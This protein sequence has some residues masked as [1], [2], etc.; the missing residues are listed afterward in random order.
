M[1][2]QRHSQPTWRTSLT[3][4]TSPWQRATRTPRVRPAPP[5]RQTARHPR[6]TGIRRSRCPGNGVASW[7]RAHPTCPTR[8]N[9]PSMP[10]GS[11]SPVAARPAE[12]AGD[13]RSRGQVQTP[14]VD[15]D[16]EGCEHPSSPGYSM[17]RSPARP[18]DT[19]GA[20][21]R[22]G[23]DTAALPR[24]GTPRAKIQNLALCPRRRPG[25]KANAPPALPIPVRPPCLTFLT[26]LI[27]LT[28]RRRVGGPSAPRRRLRRR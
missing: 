11:D 13:F 4:R 7:R 26:C 20:A 14:D 28:C 9:C 3:A 12:T 24:D 23:G 10:S 16:V 27:R 15:V 6:P 22:F 25:A 17:N 5:A 18:P 19:C 8:P 1:Q 2:E 21:H